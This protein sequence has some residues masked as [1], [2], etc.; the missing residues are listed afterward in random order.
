ME[1]WVIIE[2]VYKYIDPYFLLSDNALKFVVFYQKTCAN[3]FTRTRDGFT[4][5]KILKEIH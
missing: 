1:D 4:I 2:I 3:Y 5:S